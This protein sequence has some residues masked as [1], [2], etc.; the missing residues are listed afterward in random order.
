MED[1]DYEGMRLPKGATVLAHT[2]C[3]TVSLPAHVSPYGA[4]PY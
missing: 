3:V 1:D 2:W 4:G